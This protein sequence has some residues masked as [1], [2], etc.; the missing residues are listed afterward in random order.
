MVGHTLKKKN[1]QIVYDD[2]FNF[3]TI[4]LFSYFP[5]QRKNIPPFF[6]NC[7]LLTYTECY[8]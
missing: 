2:K 5:C 8:V 7:K 3:S 1:H 6:K 4:L